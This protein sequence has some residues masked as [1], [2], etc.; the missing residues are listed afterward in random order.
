MQT[1]VTVEAMGVWTKM[2][3]VVISR[4]IWQDIVLL[5]VNVCDF[6]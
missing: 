3:L 2:T 6:I 1:E 4:Y 5:S